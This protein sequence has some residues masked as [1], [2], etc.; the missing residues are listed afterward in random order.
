MKKLLYLLVLQLTFSFAKAQCPQVFDYLGNPSSNPYWISCSGG[1]YTLNFQSPSSWGT[2]TLNWGDGSPVVIGGSYTAN[3]ILTHVY[4]PTVDTFVVD[5]I[6]PS[7]CS[8]QGVV[9]MEL[10]V[11]AI[12]S[13]PPGGQ[14]EGCSPATFSFSNIS[15][16]VSQT[17]H[18]QW[19]FGDGSP[20]VNMT[21]TNANQVVSHLYTSA[22]V[23]CQTQVTLHAWNYCSFTS[24]SSA[25]LGPLNV[26]DKDVSSIA[27]SNA[28]KCWPDNAFTFSSTSTQNCASQGNNYPRYQYWKLGNYW[29]INSFQDS[30]IPWT[31]NPSGPQT[32]AFPFNGFFT[33]MLVDSNICGVD[34]SYSSVNLFNAP[35]AG[36]IAPP[37]PLC[38]NTSIT[39]SN[40]SSSGALYKWDFGTGPGFF[41]LPPGPQAFTYTTPGTYT[42]RVVAYYPFHN[43]CSDTA[44][45]VINILPAPTPNFTMSPT[46]GCDVLSNV[47]FTDTSVGAVN[48]FWDFGN[49]NFSFSQFPPSQT[50]TAAGTQFITLLITGANGCQASI[51]NTVE[52]YPSPTVSFTADFVCEGSVTSF[53]NLST[54]TFSLPILS[55]TW[56]FGDATATSSLLNPT[57]T[58]SA[59]GVYNVTLTASNAQCTG[60]LVQG[61][62]VYFK[63]IPSFVMSPTVGCNPL[64]VTFTNTSTGG[65]NSI[66]NFGDGSP[67]TTV[68]SPTHTYAI[69]STVNQTYTVTL[70]ITNNSGCS[71]STKKVVQ[72]LGGP[73][74]NITMNTPNSCPPIV[75]TFTNSSLNYTAFVWDFGN[76]QT[77]TTMTATSTFTNGSTTT[78]TFYPIKL[79][80]TAA[81]G[82]KD[83]VVKN[84][85]VFPKPQAKFIVDTPVCA[86]KV[87][88]FTNQTVGGTSYNWINTNPN[89]N[90]NPNTNLTHIFTN[91]LT[92]PISNTTQLVAFNPNGC[93]D[94]TKLSF[95]IHPSPSVPITASRDSGCSVLK[96]SFSSLSSLSNLKWNLGNGNTPTLT[97]PA[98]SYLNNGS[99]TRNY[100]VTLTADDNFGCSGKGTKVIKVFPKPI[101]LFTASPDTVYLPNASPVVVNQ[102]TGAAT[103]N[104]TFGDGATS[105]SSNPTY[106]YSAEGIYQIELI[107]KS[108]KGCTDTFAL[109]SKIQVLSLDH[110][111]FP[112]AFTP[113]TSG[114]PGKIYDPKDLSNDIFH[115]N[116]IGV[117]KYKMSIYSRWGELMFETTN[118]KEGWDGY[119]KGVLCAADV[120]VCKIYAKLVSGLEINRTGNVTLLR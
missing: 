77:A 116:I 111:D 93:S 4:N 89:P 70:V 91:T 71:D 104:W 103:Y 114:S 64:G 34:T 65:I 32:V 48:W 79:V 101:A 80:V 8:I 43:S 99:I 105:T 9:V 41:T 107:A 112:N 63:P 90:I 72:K 73:V 25:V 30:I 19:D 66:W 106:N 35:V 115:P 21:Y 6:I 27:S 78:N 37:A 10:P 51:I 87:I 15:T 67:T 11:N 86:N 118:Y 13:V 38:Q 44:Q 52:V 16:D 54:S 95:L 98:T 5:V 22:N 24:T 33:V 62:Q 82:C 20:L 39:F 2:Y 36:V 18:F 88:T 58:Y 117:E 7:L 31:P 110:I 29:A 61:V 76:G 60:S 12:V 102:S 46:T 81:N 68:V 40:T 94:T 108:S 74:P 97:L 96:V 119:Y 85:F 57:H 17:T 113:N 92:T 53:T 59:G 69:P 56:N 23:T 109:A 1:P 100:T 83:S 55:Y 47:T 42:V 84:F 45:V 14:T 3:S 49:S 120:Y 28:I 26:F 75:A 50:Y